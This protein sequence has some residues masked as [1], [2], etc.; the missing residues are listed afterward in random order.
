MSISRI[1]VVDNL[2]DLLSIKEYSAPWN[3]CDNKATKLRVG[4]QLEN[5]QW[6]Q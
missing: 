3:Y 5:D 4:N 1:A 2:Y 6:S